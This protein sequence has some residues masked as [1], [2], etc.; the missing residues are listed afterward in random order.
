M[1]HYAAVIKMRFAWAC[2]TNVFL[3]TFKWLRRELSS[4]IDEACLCV[5]NKM[6]F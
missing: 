5:H 4:S 2:L 1:R 3:M 6:I